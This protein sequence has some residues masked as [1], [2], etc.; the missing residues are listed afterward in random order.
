MKDRLGDKTRLLHIIDA[1][2]AVEDYTNM[3]EELDFLS[4]QMMYDAVMMK[5]TIIGEA[6]SRLSETLIQQNSNVPWVRIKGLR[7]LLVHEY[8]AVDTSIIWGVVKNNLP[9]FKQQIQNILAD[10]DLT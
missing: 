6:V 2:Q 1:I 3:V 7:N 4:N 10:F 5:L 9:P 8:F